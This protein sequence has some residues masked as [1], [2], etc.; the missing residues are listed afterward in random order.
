M[1]FSTEEINESDLTQIMRLIKRNAVFKRPAR[2]I[3]PA[4]RSCIFL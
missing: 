3:Y 1:E 4:S 2:R